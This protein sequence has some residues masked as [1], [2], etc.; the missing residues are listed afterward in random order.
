MLC[1]P[2]RHQQHEA[3]RHFAVPVVDVQFVI[4]GHLDGHQHR[5]DGND[6][7]LGFAGAN[8]VTKEQDFFQ[9]R[10]NFLFDPLF[11]EKNELRVVKVWGARGAHNCLK[12]C[13]H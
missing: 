12:N 8:T 9:I 1:A 4:L 10:V 2:V 6:I 3:S 7:R 13:L 5:L 11:A